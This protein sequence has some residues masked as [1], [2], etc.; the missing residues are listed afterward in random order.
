MQLPCGNIPAHS[1]WLQKSEGALLPAFRLAATQSAILWMPTPVMIPYDTSSTSSPLP[2]GMRMSLAADKQHVICDGEGCKAVAR[3]PVALRSLL[4][5]NRVS[6][7]QAVDGWLFVASGGCWRNYC[8]RCTPRYIA[9][10][11][12]PV[13]DADGPAKEGAADGAR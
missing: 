11:S 2:D 6:D 1:V 10:L 4:A 8:P 9:S 5:P 7:P 3:L 12:E 13:V